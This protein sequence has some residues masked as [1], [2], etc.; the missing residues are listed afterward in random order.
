MALT[1]HGT[2]ADN[3]AV[4]DRR[5]AKPIFINGAME[6]WQRGTALAS[7]SGSYAADRFWYALSRISAYS[8]FL[9][10]ITGQMN[11]RIYMCAST[12]HCFLPDR[13]GRGR[14]APL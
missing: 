3:T 8:P 6:I 13:G 14:G 5:S 9:F 4:L 2:V 7:S 11:I 1:L 12:V 10:R